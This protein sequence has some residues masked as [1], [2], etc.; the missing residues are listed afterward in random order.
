MPGLAWVNVTRTRARS[1]LA[2]AG[3]AVAVAVLTVVVGIIAAFR[4]AVVGTLLGSAV[5]VQVR[6]SDYA[7]AA[8]IVV[9]TGIGVAN[10]LFLSI[11]ER[12]A[13]LPTATLLAEE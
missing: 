5:T 3:L 8:A 11:R 6:G 12:G 13:A 7:A 10:V 1:T 4:G 2:A 9:L